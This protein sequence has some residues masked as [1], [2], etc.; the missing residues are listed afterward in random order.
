MRGCRAT[1][2]RWWCSTRCCTRS[3]RRRSTQWV[4]ASSTAPTFA[5][6]SGGFPATC[7]R[8]PGRRRTCI[9]CCGNGPETGKP[10]P[11]VRPSYVELVLA[12]A[13]AVLL[14]LSAC[15]TPYQPFEGRPVLAAIRFEG[16]HSISGAGLLDHTATAPTSGFFSK[17][18]RYYDADLFAIDIK[19]I[20]RWYNE[21]GFYEA[22]I[23]DVRE[24]PDD[25][26]RVPVIV[27]IDEGRRAFLKQMDFAGVEQLEQGE[28]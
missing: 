15:A 18:A 1:S 19:R 9:C 2:W 17:T 24:Q 22:Q 28:V 10:A 7:G 25:K 26:G 6:P 14:L 5:P 27:K 23:K 13:L 11:P 3:I 16:N 4:A 21:K 20:D 8:A 12:R